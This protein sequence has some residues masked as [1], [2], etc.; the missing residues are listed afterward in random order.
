MHENLCRKQFGTLISKFI[1]F[2]E[3]VLYEQVFLGKSNF[4]QNGGGRN[5]IC[6]AAFCVAKCFIF[7]IF[8]VAG[9][10]FISASLLG[11][12]LSALDLV[13]DKE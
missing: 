1:S 12:V 10:G 13:S 9:N 3:I 4:S 6:L 7:V 2:K 8:V 5:V 11:D